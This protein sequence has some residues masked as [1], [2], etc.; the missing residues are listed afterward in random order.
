[1]L[2][3][4]SNKYL[5]QYY[6]SDQFLL[7]YFANIEKRLKHHYTNYNI[8]LLKVDRSPMRIFYINISYIH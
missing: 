1:M 6:Q 2:L 7:T 5:R 8:S 4:F 3:Q